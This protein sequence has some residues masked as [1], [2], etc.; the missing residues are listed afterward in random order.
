MF[1][2]H[3]ACNE[4]N[5]FEI[6]TKDRTVKITTS[7]SRY[8]F[9]LEP[10]EKIE[11]LIEEKAEDDFKLPILKGLQNPNNK[12]TPL[13]SDEDKAI[14][15]KSLEVTCK[16]DLVSQS[17]NNLTTFFTNYNNQKNIIIE[18]EQSYIDKLVSI[19][20][21]NQQL[22]DLNQDLEAK[23]KFI[24]KIEENQSRLR[25]NIKSLE[26]V[27]SDKLIER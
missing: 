17:M 16:I 24:K 12:M 6:L 14:I 23:R 11:Y 21:K 20:D 3:A 9:T 18:L 4:K 5:G 1:I 7:F 10:N 22:T 26:K 13:A 15:K 25:E 8:E 19:Q 2:D 27:K